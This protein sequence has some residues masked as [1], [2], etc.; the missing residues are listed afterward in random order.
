MSKA[1]K[2]DRDKAP[3][4]LI[5]YEAQEEIA[6]VLAFGA[7]KYGRGNFTGGLEYSR[8]LSAAM[9]HLG[10]FNSGQ[11]LDEESGLSHV[12]HAG[13][14]IA[15]LLYMMKHKPEMDDRW[16]RAAP[17]AP[18]EITPT[19]PRNFEVRVGKWYRR[20]D[21]IVVGPMIETPR[22]EFVPKNAPRG[23]N[24]TYTRE[25]AWIFNVG[26]ALTPS[27]DLVAEERE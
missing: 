2:F 7:K 10:Q 26:R 20:R 15:F 8:L 12:A 21:H 13:C 3:L 1:K 17:K 9:R 27:L 25:G 14:M 11:D 24:V 4:D 23:E 22:G 18:T 5:P 16:D 19:P 6:R